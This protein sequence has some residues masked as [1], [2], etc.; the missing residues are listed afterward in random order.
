MRDF[1]TY[2]R[3]AARHAGDALNILYG[4]QEDATAV[5]A[6]QWTNGVCQVQVQWQDSIIYREHLDA[7]QARGYVP[8]DD[9]IQPAPVKPFGVM[10]AKKLIHVKWQPTFESKQHMYET[11]PSFAELYRIFQVARAHA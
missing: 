4:R 7:Y 11:Q 3:Q 6:E 2:I 1:K 8:V 10:L 9:G 5:L